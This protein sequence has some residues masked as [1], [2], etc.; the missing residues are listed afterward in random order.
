M[1]IFCAN[2][3]LIENDCIYKNEFNIGTSLTCQVR[4]FDR[5]IGID[6]NMNFQEIIED[7]E[8]EGV[9]LKGYAFLSVDAIVRSIKNELSREMAIHIVESFEETTEDK[10]S[11]WSI[12]RAKGGCQ[13]HHHQKSGRNEA[14]QS[15]LSV[16]SMILSNHGI[17]RKRRLFSSNINATTAKSSTEDKIKI[18]E[19]DFNKRGKFTSTRRDLFL[20][21]ILQYDTSINSKLHVEPFVYSSMIAHPFAR[22]VIILLASLLPMLREILKYKEVEHVEIVRANIASFNLMR[23]FMPELDDCSGYALGNGNNSCLDNDS[24]KRLD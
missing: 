15:P 4:Y 7:V 19:Y 8:N 18:W 14:S 9:D 6:V 20:D 17:E 3:V 13:T 5:L 12:H 2:D 10:S 23:I 11:F 22:R 1:N 16:K 24:V 21:S